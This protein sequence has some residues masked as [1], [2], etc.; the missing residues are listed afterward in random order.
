M[1]VTVSVVIT[2]LAVAALTVPLTFFLHPDYGCSDDEPTPLPALEDTLRVNCYPGWDEATE[3]ECRKRGCVYAQP[4]ANQ[5]APKCYFPEKYGGYRMVGKEAETAN[6]Y[7]VT[8]DRTPSTPTMFGNDIT[9]LIL[10]VE[11]HTE[12]RLRFKV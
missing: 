7:R 10:D 9:R 8:L 4:T 1:A 12:Y 3:E 2:A 11:F 5:A 6:G